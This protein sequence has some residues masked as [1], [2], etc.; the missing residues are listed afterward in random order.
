MTR[1]DQPRHRPAWA[2]LGLLLALGALAACD[3]SHQMV[4]AVTAPPTPTVAPDTFQGTIVCAGSAALAPLVRRAA[5]E[6]NRLAPNAFVLVITS[7][8]QLGLST[9]ADDGADIALADVSAAD[10]LVPEAENFSEYH[11]GAVP[12]AVIVNQAAGVTNLTR[13]D[14]RRI[15]TGQAQ[16]W[17]EVGGAAHSITPFQASRGSGLQYLFE[18]SFAL[19]DRTGEDQALANSTTSSNVLRDVAGTPGAIGYTPSGFVPASVQVVAIDGVLPTV[20]T[21][22]G[23]TYPFWSY[24]RLYTKYPAGGLAHAFISYMQGATL[25]GKIVEQLG[26][27]PLA[28][29]KDRRQP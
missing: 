19:A 8:S 23:G 21:V 13:H 5:A 3:S 10:V 14:L 1:S 15:Y 18:K 2:L 6:F 20:D 22:A 9:L 27:V 28:Q 29:M 7:T 17:R 16:N 25:Q 24:A 4:G 12:Y 26:I 11:V